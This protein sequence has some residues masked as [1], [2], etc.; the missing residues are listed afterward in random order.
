MKTGGAGKVDPTIT[1]D[2]IS[3]SP[4]RRGAYVCIA[5][6]FPVSINRFL[7]RVMVGEHGI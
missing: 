5:Y 1:I 7:R 4:V 3:E 6:T 2:M